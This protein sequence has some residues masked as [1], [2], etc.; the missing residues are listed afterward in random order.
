MGAPPTPQSGDTAH[1]SA[2]NDSVRQLVVT[3]ADPALARASRANEKLDANYDAALT[4]AAAAPLHVKRAMSAGAWVIELMQAVDGA[5]ALAVAHAL[6]ASGIAR[7]A[8]PDYPVYP[9][10]TPN[11]TYFHSG[12]QWYL[13][14]PASLKGVDA[15]HAWDLTTG[16]PAMVIAIVDSGLVPHPDL[17]PARIVTGYDF[18]TSLPTANDGDGRDAD[19]SDP[20]DGRIEGFCASPRDNATN[21]DWHG[22]FVAGII[23]ATSNNSQGIAGVNWNAR[24][25][26]VRVLGR[27]GGS[28]SD[29]LDGATWA[30]GLPVPGAP[31]NSTPARVINMSLSGNGACLPQ[32]Q[33]IFDQILAAGAL[34]VVAA[35]NDNAD[36]GDY[37][38]ASCHGILTVAATNL[39]G[40]RASYS[41]FG[42]R[43]DISAPGGDIPGVG[44]T[45][46]IIST[47]NSGTSAPVSANYRIG[48]GTSFSSAIVS[49]IASLMVSVNPNLT[50][51]Q[52]KLL[53]TTTATPFPDGADCLTGICGAG[54]VNAYAA[55]QAAQAGSLQ[56]APTVVVEFYNPERNHFF[57]SANAQEIRDLDTGVHPGWQR[58]RLSFPAYLTN[59][60]GFSPVCR[61]YIPPANGDSHFF[62]ASPTECAQTH[63]KFPSFIAEAP[64]VFYIGLPDAATGVCPIGTIPVYRV[65]DNRADANHRYT[66]S[67]AVIDQMKAIGWIVEGYGPGP[68]YP[69]MC[70]PQ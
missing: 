35:G 21:S 67:T 24:I 49:G 65:F 2:A 17:A 39:I 64:D 12:D 46:A 9:Q 68:Y 34:V 33:A 31:G 28:T 56:P 54:I 6:E 27:C 50:P 32:Y 44:N 70:A 57:I 8:A 19:P 23:G 22:T 69:I 48:D 30:A 11:D 14:P 55:V 62:S 58:T 66:T 52:I 47:S 42:A 60:A 18:I 53:M 1:S 37:E 40:M 4:K 20:G 41:N 25:Q 16:D 3:F 45:D 43:I 38:P 29:I 15:V 51:A 63:A 5:A 26:P 10:L 36:V 13:N 59:E 7:M 61:F